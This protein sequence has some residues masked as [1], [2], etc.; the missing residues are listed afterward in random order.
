MTR[1]NMVGRGPGHGGAIVREHSTSSTITHKR[2]FRSVVM[3][4]KMPRP[5]MLC[6]AMLCYYICYAMLC[7]AIIYILCWRVAELRRRRRAAVDAVE[8][9]A[10]QMPGPTCPASAD[11]SD[12]SAADVCRTPLH[13]LLGY[14]REMD[15][16]P[17]LRRLAWR[18]ALQ[19]LFRDDEDG[20]VDT[21]LV[22]R[23]ALEASRSESSR[24]RPVRRVACGVWRL[25]S[26]VWRVA[27]GVR[28]RPLEKTP[29]PA[30]REYSRLALRTASPSKML[31]PPRP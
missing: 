21:S 28:R 19:I 31:A 10:R 25:A 20:I 30:R 8:L 29:R 5:H 16:P 9:R 6:Y 24:V 22:R 23:R 2:V 26:G 15:A 14:K 4:L 3:M 1:K 13:E 18:V 17:A 7:Y 27:C 11:P 12:E